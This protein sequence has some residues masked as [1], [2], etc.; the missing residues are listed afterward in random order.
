LIGS[1]VNE[2]GGQ[3]LRRFCER[4]WAKMGG[5]WLAQAWVGM[6]QATRLLRLDRLELMETAI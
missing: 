3:C 2:L 1:D 4:E 6:L 5:A